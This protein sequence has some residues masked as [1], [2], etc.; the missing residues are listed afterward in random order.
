MLDTVRASM[1]AQR[2]RLATISTEIEQ[3]TE[4]KNAIAT[5]LAGFGQLANL[6]LT[7]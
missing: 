2:N 6:A 3:L 1:D 4:E 5:E 7:A